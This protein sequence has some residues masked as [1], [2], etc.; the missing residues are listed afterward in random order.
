MSSLKKLLATGILV[1]MNMPLMLAAMRSQSLLMVLPP[2]HQQGRTESLNISQG[3]RTTLAVGNG[4][5]LTAAMS[6]SVGTISMS[7]S[8]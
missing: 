8:S 2:M 6:S 5:Q 4:V 1:G 3:A 7:R